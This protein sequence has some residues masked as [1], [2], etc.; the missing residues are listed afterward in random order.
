MKTAISHQEL[1]GGKAGIAF[2]FGNIL[3][4]AAVPVMLRHLAGV[5]DA[6]TA[7]GFRYPLAGMLYWPILF[8]AWQSNRLDATVVRRCLVPSLLAMIAQVFWALAPYHLPATAIGFFVRLSLLWSLIAAMILF[9]DE[10]RLLKLPSFYAGLALLI[11]GFLMLSISKLRFDQQVTGTGIVIILSCAFFFGL[12]AVSV[13]YFLGGINP[14]VSFGVVCQFV[15][16]GT[17]VAMLC[18][19]EYSQLLEI[20]AQNWGLLVMSAILGI[21]LGHHFLY[22]AVT[23]LG[24]AVT[25]GAQT[26]APFLTILLAATFLGESMSTIEWCGG[27]MM[28]VGAALLLIAQNQ[29][30]ARS[31][32]AAVG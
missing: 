21:A 5:V 14:M 27:V 20:S 1:S 28:V 4:W 13:R 24:A 8:V 7:N 29:L 11:V 15:S 23:R 9:R 3:C 2:L 17:F 16:I 6:W 26:L 12:Y 22:S 19:G 18:F 25:S 30:V 10:R 31:R 32:A